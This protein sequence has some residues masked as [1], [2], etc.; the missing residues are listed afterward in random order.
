M[1]SCG[2][3]TANG[4]GTKNAIKDMLDA[5]VDAVFMPHRTKHKQK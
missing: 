3:L 5:N 1:I 2:G 4:K